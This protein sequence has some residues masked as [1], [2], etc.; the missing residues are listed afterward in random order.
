MRVPGAA[1]GWGAKRPLARR[2]FGP[3]SSAPF[4]QPCLF[5]AALPRC[6]LGGLSAESAWGPGVS[7][8]SCSSELGLNWKTFRNGKSE[9]WSGVAG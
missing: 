3:I 2:G 1:R 5:G 7:R 9:A 8:S 6:W 4:L